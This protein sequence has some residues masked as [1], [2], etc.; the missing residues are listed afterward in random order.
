VTLR[1][2]CHPS[3]MTELRGYWPKLVLIGSQALCTYVPRLS[4]PLL[5]PFLVQEYGYSEA[6]RARLLGAFFPGYMLTMV[7]LGWVAQ[8]WS[9]RAILQLGNLG[10]AASMLLLPTM[11]AAG[12]NGA[13][14]CCLLLGLL[15]GPFVPAHNQLKCNW[16]VDGPSKPLAL[17]VIGLGLFL[18]PVCVGIRRFIQLLSAVED[19]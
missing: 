1:V 3:A 4:L 9:A 15:Q 14:A 5:V 16:V 2:R 6:A 7:P 19:T 12:P 8:R 18:I 17:M 10:T 13:A 11:A